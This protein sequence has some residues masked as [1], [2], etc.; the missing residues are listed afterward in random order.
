MTISFVWKCEAEYVLIHEAHGHMNSTKDIQSSVT[1][2]E[3]TLTADIDIRNLDVT[4]HKSD[5]VYVFC[6]KSE[7]TMD[8]INSSP[9]S[10][11]NG[12]SK[13][14]VVISPTP[15]NYLGLLSDVGVEC[16]VVDTAD[17]VYTFF[18]R[19]NGKIHVP[20]KRRF[21]SDQ[22]MPLWLHKKSP[23]HSWVEVMTLITAIIIMSAV[24]LVMGIHLC[25]QKRRNGPQI[26]HSK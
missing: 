5:T 10:F 23:P 24:P 15:T 8:K 13:Y 9:P 17:R 14:H 26:I 22:N 4:L 11:S 21:R 16:S 12:V 25:L 1:M 7:I 18:V 3:T 19:L 20:H 2:R 6:G